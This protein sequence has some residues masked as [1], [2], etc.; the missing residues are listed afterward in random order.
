MIKTKLRLIL[1]AMFHGFSL[2]EKQSDNVCDLV[3]AGSGAELD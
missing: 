3:E 2:F 1:R